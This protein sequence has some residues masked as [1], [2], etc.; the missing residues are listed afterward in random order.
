MKRLA[1]IV[2]Y[3][4]RDAHLRQLLS[5]LPEK[6]NEGRGSA[7]QIPYH[8]YV[9]EQA[10]L[11]SFNKAKLLNAAFSLLE[12]DY[13]YFCFHDVD[14]LPTHADY[15][16]VELPTHLAADVSQFREW[17]GKGLAYPTYFGGV[18]LFNKAD[19]KKVNG[20]SNFYWGYG[21]EDDDMLYRI[22]QHGLKWARR[23]GVFESLDH[24]P[25]GGTEEHQQNK[26]HLKAILEGTLVDRSGLSDLEYLVIQK[27]ERNGYTHLS[28][29]I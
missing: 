28:V 26:K 15:S 4:D 8:I 13:D 16:Y 22:H 20:Y 10:N 2:P 19:F 23:Q 25:G 21:L 29:D 1:I 3:R 11:K 24:P 18:V 6:V 9:V 27:I 7:E 12:K 5:I 17:E 14:M